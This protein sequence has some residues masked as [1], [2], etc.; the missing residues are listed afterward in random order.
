MKKWTRALYQPNLPLRQREYVTGCEEHIRLSA[1][2]A[3][4][5]MVLLK[6]DGRVLPLKPAAKVAVF[7]K[8][9]F[10]YVKGGGGSGD[11]Y[12]SYIRNLPEGLEMT[13]AEVF[14]PLSEFYRTYVEKCYS[15]GNVP[16]M[17]EEP[18][19]PG[20]LLEEAAG[21]TDTAIVVFSRFSGEA[22]DRCGA[23]RPKTDIPEGQL[24]M[25][26]A[27]IFPEGDFYLSSR[28]K[29]VLSLVAGRFSKV[30]AVLNTGGVVDT[31][32]IRDDDRVSAALLAWQGGMEGGLAA[33]R[34]LMGQTCPSGKLP[35][36][37]TRRLEDYPS[38]ES[39]MK[40]PDM[41]EYTEDIYVGYRY[42]ETIP[43]AAGKVVYPF[44]Y[45]LSYTRFERTVVSAQREEGKTVFRVRVANTGEVPGK[46]VLQI[47]YSA[48]SGKLG[49]PARE[50]GAFAKTRMLEPG[51]SEELTLEIQDEQ[52]ASYDD[53]GKLAKSAWILEKGT[54]RFFLGGSVREAS[55]VDFTWGPEEDVI[56]ASLQPRLVP[57]RL[58]RRLLQDGT[59]EDMPAASEQNQEK[60]GSAA[61]GFSL[62]DSEDI[63]EAAF[64]AVRGYER[65]YL[66]HRRTE[67][68]IQL[69]EV[70]EGKHTLEEFLQALPDEDLIWLTGG[71]ANIGVA[72][73]CGFGG[74][75]EY[76]VPAVMTADGPAGVR[77][78][79]EC[80]VATTAWPCETLLAS[81]WNTELMAS[82]GKAAGEELKEN[83]LQIWL[84]PAVNIHRNPLCGRN[85][86]YL[87]EDPLL[88]GKMGASEVRGIQENHVA[89]SVKHFACNNKETNRR[90]R[91]SVVSERAL[92][93]IYLKVFEIVVKEADPWTIM[94]SYNII[95]GCRSS[96]N[97][98]LLTDILRD[99]WGFKGMITTDW[100]N[101]AEQYK[102]ILAG[103]DV[104]MANGFDE[105]VKAALEAGALQRE[106]VEKCAR[107]VLEMILKLD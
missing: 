32:W 45:G 70:A 75:P 92:R 23:D 42:F 60:T 14:R 64:P 3:G 5:G 67:G 49:K 8:G 74:L 29:A 27:R 68:K 86:E 63:H 84:A 87:S 81:T 30:I 12:T 91:D 89:A 52:M 55:P 24:V 93:E 62:P 72:N 25:Q 4:E 57:S 35:D 77:I 33:A 20:N 104:K 97:K 69:L 39:F 50:L 83:N 107:R 73:T 99:E 38:T 61:S 58:S 41:V 78:N 82:V 19:L 85:F 11:V 54:Y 59:Y 100:W 18:E 102:E 80:G 76:G 6:N 66:C 34:I 28:E 106:D 43:G 53:T 36:T 48:P 56:L 17:M 7:G 1:E 9:S 94:T 2:A 65:E 22:W 95:N 51:Q 96:E 10:D 71:R 46:E 21:Y 44:G 103:N 26:A 40:S 31:S 47:Y 79:P 101:L 16:G 37:F 105:R 15:E 98:E 13:G 90:N 88:A